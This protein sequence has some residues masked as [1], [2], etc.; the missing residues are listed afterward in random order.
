MKDFMKTNKKFM[1]RDSSVGISTVY[2]LDDQDSIHRR[3]RNFFL[4]SRPALRLTQ[5]PI[6]LEFVALFPEVKR[7][8]REVDHSPL[9]SGKVKNGGAIP[10]H[11]TSI[12]LHDV[13]PNKLSTET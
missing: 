2:G 8:G 7:P 13:V 5:F 12:R 4:L 1:Y 10:A 3:A 9:S 6:Q 11:H